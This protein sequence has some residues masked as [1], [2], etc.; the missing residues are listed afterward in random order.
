MIQKLPHVTKFA[1][2]REKISNECIELASKFFFLQSLLVC[3]K[4]V[5]CT[6][7]KIIYIDDPIFNVQCC[8]ELYLQYYKFFMFNAFEVLPT[9]RLSC[10][11]VKCW[12]KVI[13]M[14]LNGH[15]LHFHWICK[16]Y[17]TDNIVDMYSKIILY[18]CIVG[19]NLSYKPVLE[20]HRQWILEKVFKNW[21]TILKYITWNSYV[22]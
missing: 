8:W 6:S 14:C 9:S 19:A 13:C 17:I 16:I 18:H 10:F 20:Q 12:R 1:E 4:F 5:Y 2:D 22:H 3:K 11:Y 7:Y 15:I 21:N